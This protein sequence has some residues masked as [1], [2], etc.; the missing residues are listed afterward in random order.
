M[1]VHNP[2]CYR[3]CVPQRSTHTNRNNGRQ[4]K[5]DRRP[6]RGRQY[7]PSRTFRIANRLG[8]QTDLA[9]RS[10]TPSHS[11]NRVD[12]ASVVSRTLV[13]PGIRKDLDS[14]I[15]GDAQSRRER[16]NINHNGQV[17][18]SSNRFGTCS[19]PVESKSVLELAMFRIHGASIPEERYR[20]F[21]RSFS[22]MV[23]VPQ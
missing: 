7:Q 10:H 21:V 1:F 23:R 8:R 6:V 11:Q 19:A 18:T 12:V 2:I 17:N 15:S 5:R 16:E 9:F 20:R 14:C 22:S 3:R 4:R 13:V